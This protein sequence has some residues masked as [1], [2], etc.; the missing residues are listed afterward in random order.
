VLPQA[1][2]SVNSMTDSSD[3]AAV[4]HEENLTASIHD[5]EVVI[6]RRVSRAYIDR[7][8]S[9]AD[10]GRSGAIGIHAVNASGRP[11]LLG[12][13][14]SAQYHMIHRGQ[15]SS[16]VEM[17]HDEGAQGQIRTK[18]R[19]FDLNSVIAG[20]GAVRAHLVPSVLRRVV[21]LRDGQ[22]NRCQGKAKQ[23]VRTRA[24]SKRLFLVELCFI[25]PPPGIG[26]AF[27]SLAILST[28]TSGDSVG[29]K[30]PEG[31]LKVNW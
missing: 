5:H 4:D 12:G 29:F 14:L 20:D 8:R 21:R 15:I 27:D 9:G 13:R 22:A 11:P 10:R 30:Y 26:E 7:G 18:N 23:S 19:A 28:D 2:F 31:R 3:C 16:T 1:T 24:T 25:N 17:F 6:E